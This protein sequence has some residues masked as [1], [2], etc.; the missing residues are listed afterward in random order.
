MKKTTFLFLIAIFLATFS[1]SQIS[2]TGLQFNAMGDYV[3]VPSSPAY[4]IGTGNFTLEMWIRMNVNQPFG[5][6]R[7]FEVWKFTFM[8]SSPLAQPTFIDYSG[9][10]QTLQMHFG[11]SHLDYNFSPVILNDGICHHL[12]VVRAGANLTLYVDGV[13]INTLNQS[14]IPYLEPYTTGPEQNAHLAFGGLTFPPS[15]GNYSG[16]MHEVRVWNIARSQTDIQS[17]MN[18]MLAG[19]ETGL[20]GYWKFNDGSGPSVNDFSSNNNDGTLSGLNTVPTF[21]AGCSN[22]ALPSSSVSASGP[23]TFCST[24]SPVQLS[25]L[26][27]YTYQWYRDRYILPGET[28]STL[29]AGASGNYNCVISNTCGSVTSN[30]ITVTVNGA[31][32][33]NV[34]VS[35]PISFCPPGSVT[36]YASTGS[37]FSYQWQLNNNPIAGAT[38]VSYVATASGSYNCIVSGNC[39][40]TISYIVTVNA[41]AAPHASISGGSTSVCAPGSASLHANTGS[42]LSYQWKLNGLNIAGA[43]SSSYTATA[44]GNY[45]CVVSNSCGSNTSNTISV[46]FNSVPVANIT[47]SG[48]TAVCSPNS[49]TL[50]ANTGTGLSYQWKLNGVNISGATSSSYNATATGNYNCSVSNICGSTPSNTIAVTVT[51][52]PAQPTPIQGPTSVCHN[53]NNVTYGITAVSGA[54]SY[55]WTVPAGTQ[56]KSGQ[57]TPTI[58]VRFGNSAGNIT[59]TANNACGQSPVRTLAIAMP[60]REGEE[61]SAEVFDVTLYPNPI[62]SELRIENAELRIKEIEIYSS[63]G[64]KIISQISSLKSQ[65][66]VDVSQLSPGIYFITVTDQARNKVTKKVVKM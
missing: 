43:T 31:P 44:T 61:I 2:S 50:N 25:A 51:A 22:C 52:I 11:V 45:N 49:V 34:S 29:L 64:E 4:N 58:K 62:T 60:C 57:G 38:A 26:P 17:T 35:G 32:P 5:G 27:G 54:T 30:T 66:S 40:S 18:V 12:A 56:I 7:L 37:G 9:T 8:Q 47:A 42:G 14:V 36:I 41:N 20:I 48:S 46:T 39:G 21:I 59:V 63:I 33:P 28:N 16:F 19:N 53:Q 6:A 15:G 23:L 3:G 65:I 1:F 10:T 13:L 24:S 55:T